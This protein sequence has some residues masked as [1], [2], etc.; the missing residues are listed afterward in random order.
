MSDTE[1]Q[2]PRR[3]PSRRSHLDR[4]VDDYG[5]ARGI[6]PD[7]IRR[8]ISVIS[9]IGALDAVQASDGPRFL[10]KGGVA[11]ELRLGLRARST[12]DVDVVFRG[13]PSEM[14]D[15]MDEAF[16]PTAGGFS[17]RRKGP[18]TTIRDTGSRRRA[19]RWASP[20]VTGKH[21]KS[22]SGHRRSTRSSSCRWRSRENQRYWDLIDLVL[23]RQRVGDDIHPT[24][25]ACIEV[26]TGRG[27]HAWPPRLIVPKAWNGPYR[28]AAATIDADTPTDVENAA[29]EVRAFITE[30]DMSAR[31]D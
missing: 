26:F 4:L 22:R 2:P 27:T 10:I 18:V 13:A 6:A 17:F 5:R 28:A 11:M 9:F 14:L 8:W 20:G 29:E 12:R 24:R 1:F 19:C 23:L 31:S 16:E 21:C 3:V 7:R 25:I 15:A 30:I